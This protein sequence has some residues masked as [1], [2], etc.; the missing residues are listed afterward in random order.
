MF[1]IIASI[2]ILVGWPLSVYVTLRQWRYPVER[3]YAIEEDGRFM[4]EKAAFEAVGKWYATYRPGYYYFEC[5]EM[6]RKLLLTSFIAVIASTIDGSNTLALFVSAIVALFFAWYFAAKKPLAHIGGNHMQVL[7]HLGLASIYMGRLTVSLSSDE[8]GGTVYAPT[9]T[10]TMRILWLVDVMMLL[11]IVYAVVD[12]LRSV[13]CGSPIVDRLTRRCCRCSQPRLIPASRALDFAPAHIRAP[14]RV[15]ARR[16]RRFDEMHANLLILAS[17]IAV[18]RRAARAAQSA[19]MHAPPRATA[20]EKEDGRREREGVNDE[21]EH[22][23]KR[24]R[25]AARAVREGSRFMQTVK[26]FVGAVQMTAG[27]A[28]STHPP[29]VSWDDVEEVEARANAIFQLVHHADLGHTREGRADTCRQEE[30]AQPMRDTQA[31]RPGRI[32]LTLGDSTRVEMQHLK[33]EGKRTLVSEFLHRRLPATLRASP[34]R[35]QHVNLVYRVVAAMLTPNSDLGDIDMLS[36]VRVGDELTA[37]L[38]LPSSFLASPVPTETVAASVAKEGKGDGGG[39]GEYEGEEAK[40]ETEITRFAAAHEASEEPAGMRRDGRNAAAPN[41]GS[42]GEV[43]V[44]AHRTPVGG[45]V[46]VVSEE[47]I[48]IAV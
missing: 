19:P 40:G 14:V 12:L 25:G 43:L 11:P 20:A 15:Y 21:S 10:S 45:E 24:E 23:T 47:M 6:M 2:M 32:I 26:D 13:E 38:G 31:L 41:V 3:M 44:H 27:K 28:H 22:M 33:L 48:E 16:V 46:S 37:S 34:P 36:L 8:A 1:N 42:M 30:G 35:M 4:P 29:H 18:N 9:N 17:R 39:D 7:V 5:F